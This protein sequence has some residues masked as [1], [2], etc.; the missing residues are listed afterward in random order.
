MLLSLYYQYLKT[1]KTNQLLVPTYTTISFVFSSIPNHLSATVR[2]FKSATVPKVR[3]AISSELLF[4]SI[5]NQ[6]I[7]S[8]LRLQRMNAFVRAYLYI[9]VERPCHQRNRCFLQSAPS[10]VYLLFLVQ[11]WRT[12]RLAL[13]TGASLRRV[14]NQPGLFGSSTDDRWMIAWFFVAVKR[15]NGMITRCRW[16][17]L[18]F[19]D[20]SNNRLDNDGNRHGGNTGIV[21]TV[22]RVQLLYRL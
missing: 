7:Q 10:A 8:V 2:K 11:H 4:R 21:V 14:S 16:V 3:I 18:D 12:N 20:Y 19:V 22:P 9:D 17:I 1:I 13:G 15:A 5:C 6:G